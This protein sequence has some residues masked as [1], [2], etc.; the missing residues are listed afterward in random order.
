M[1]RGRGSARPGPAP[2]SGERALPGTQPNKKAPPPNKIRD[3]AEKQPKGS[4]VPP[5]FLPCI[6]ARPRKEAARRRKHG[7]TLVLPLTGDAVPAYWQFG[8]Q[9]RKNRPV[10]PGRSKGNFRA[11]PRPRPHR[12]SFAAAASRAG[13]SSRVRPPFTAAASGALLLSVRRWRTFLCHSVCAAYY[14]IPK[15][16]L[17]AKK[18]QKQAFRVPDCAPWT[19]PE[20]KWHGGMARGVI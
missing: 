17:Q 18:R 15:A 14:S 12:G 10:Q 8:A 5:S 7:Q 9:L 19:L 6:R 2:R 20:S 11:P 1:G 16:G 3:E 13:P 4:A